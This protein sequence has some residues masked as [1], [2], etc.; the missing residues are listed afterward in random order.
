MPL[1]GTTRKSNKIAVIGTGY[2]GLT[3]GACL[4]KLGHEVV[5]ADIIPEKV[6]SL[7]RGEIPILE[8]GLEDLVRDGLTNGRLQFVLGASQA[9]R[10][11][12]FA[13]M[14]LPTPQGADGA[15]D[16]SFLLGAVE[17][18]AAELPA[19]AIV[20]NK[21]TV[22]VGSAGQVADV[23]G[24]DDIEVVSNPE[25][26]RE[27]TAVSDFFKPSRIVLGASTKAVA[28]RVASLYRD[29]DAPKLLVDTSTAE[30]IKYASNAFLAAKISFA[31]S[32]A[33]L[34]EAV[35]A[36]AHAVLDG[37]GHDSRIGKQ[38]LKPGPGWGG[39]CFPKDTYAL[40]NI[41]EEAGYDFGLLKAVIVANDVQSQVMVNKVKAMAG[42]DVA[43]VTIAA[44]GV[45]FKAGTDD[46]RESPALKILNELS[47]LGA[48]IQVYDPGTTRVP[49]GMSVCADA[50]EACEGA[51][52]L[53]VL[54]EWPEFAQ[55]SIEEVGKRL[56]HRQVLDTRNMLDPQELAA[57]GFNFQ[58]VGRA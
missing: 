2:V 57:S 39:S 24:R 13:F 52:M 34:C 21:S 58:T 10:D 27:G 14:C 19:D 33:N 42:G 18:I 36:D 47:L 41:A 5:C 8:E 43:D 49:A 20:I 4:A 56:R 29:V 17:E 30:L 1:T 38:F 51:D 26:L 3:T 23:I 53:L 16:L 9:A 44:W 54:T 7:Q 31:N 28:A 40:I 22:P 50:L 25:F 32:I 15:A 6:D 11:C 35:G 46:T 55:V 45:T 12:D 37:M 48:N